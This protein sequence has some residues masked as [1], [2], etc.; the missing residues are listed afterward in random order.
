MK[1]YIILISVFFLATVNLRSQENKDI[2]IPLI[3]E[4]AP[5]FTAE[6]T[7][8][9]IVFPDDYF[10]KWKIL[11]SHPAAFTAVC[12]TEILELSALQKDL[13]KLNTK[14]LVISTDGQNSHLEWARSLE[15]IKYKG[16]DPQKI[17]FPLVSDLNLEISR[18][19]GMLHSASSSTKDVRGVF[20][21][22]PDDKIRAII[23]YPM[24][25]GRNMDEIKRLVIALQQAEKNNY[26]IPANW[27]P[28]QD[29]LLPSPKTV[30][31]AEQLTD[32]KDA[33]LTELTWYLWFKKIK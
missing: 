19:Y 13:D 23:F 10:G 17:R 33:S 11:F 22:D 2:R 27:E 30:K 26:L 5:A 6:S 28:G 4:P 32:S 9:K 7:Q 29:V 15:G 8:G 31:E 25:I 3:G 21:I 12:S 18:K 24:N 14:I 1:R 16:R 20:V